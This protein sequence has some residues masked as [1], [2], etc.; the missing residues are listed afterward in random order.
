MVDVTDKAKK[1]KSVAYYPGCALE[2]TGNGYDVSTRAIAKKLDLK[3]KDV[4]NWNCC[5][6][7]EVKNVDPK[8]Q[9]YLSARVLSQA[10]NMRQARRTMHGARRVIRFITACYHEVRAAKSLR[11]VISTLR[12][13]IKTWEKRL[14][15][16]LKKRRSARGTRLES[17]EPG[18]RRALLHLPRQ[19]RACASA[20]AHA[21]GRVR[22]R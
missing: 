21:P 7:M 15:N 1:Y 20:S 4:T 5:G 9:T 22:L 17:L 6:A 14:L 18:R 11:S 13:I 12:S 3:L 16:E 2:G 19:V 8:I 10:V